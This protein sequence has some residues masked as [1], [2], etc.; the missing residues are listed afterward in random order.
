MEQVVTK[1]FQS[2]YTQPIHK[3]TIQATDTG[4]FDNL[5]QYGFGHSFKCVLKSTY[6]DI[7]EGLNVATF[8]YPHLVHK[9]LF[10]LS[11]VDFPNTPFSRNLTPGIG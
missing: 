2:Y 10:S 8:K 6:L 11:N 3:H 5:N 4:A 1:T 9:V 7:N